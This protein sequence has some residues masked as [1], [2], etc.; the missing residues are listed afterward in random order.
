MKR[1]LLSHSIG[2]L[3][4]TVLVLAAVSL[5]LGCASPAAPVPTDPQPQ[6]EPWQLHAAA[7]NG[8][9]VMEQN[10]IDLHGAGALHGADWRNYIDGCTSARAILQST[11]A[12]T[13]DPAT[14]SKAIAIV[15]AAVKTG[16]A[17]WVLANAAAIGE[18][19]AAE[20]ESAGPQADEAFD[21]YVL[22][23]PD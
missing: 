22:L 19:T 8:L 7:R 9:T 10:G 4:F 13:V 23:H 21:K 6:A 1:L 14:I 2:P 16:Q 18:E 5:P 17:A 12:A 11:G 20:Y 3:L 15:K